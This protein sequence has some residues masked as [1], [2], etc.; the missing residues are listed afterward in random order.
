MTR[1]HRPPRC[2][3]VRRARVN[4]LQNLSVDLPLGEFVALTGLSGSGK[5]SL[6]MGVLYAEGSRRYLDGLPTFIRR[7]ITQATKPAVDAIGYLPATLALRQRPPVPGPRSTVGTLTEVLAVLRLAMSRLGTHRC[8]NGH[9]V[10]PTLEASVTERMTCP[11]CGATAPLPSAESF[12]FNTLGACPTCQGL[13]VTRR[14][15][16]QTLVPDDGLSLDEG[17]VAPWRMLGRQHMPLVAR[18]LGVRTDVPYRDLTDHERE[19]VLHGPEVKKH[20]VVRSG[21][22][23]PFPMNT[24]YE[25]ATRSVEMMARSDRSTTGRKSADRFLVSEVC[26]TCEGR[27]ILLTHDI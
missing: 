8:P 16:E 5:S 17:A 1:E 18:E 12:A 19:I 27:G 4:N 23:R 26:P 21:T 6:A 7:R 22:G 24:T 25:S 20:I 9:R 14:V 15:D 2:I 10:P 11:T 13:G 3:E